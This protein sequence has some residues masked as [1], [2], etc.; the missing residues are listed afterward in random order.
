MD[1]GTAGWNTF[2]VQPVLCP[3]AVNTQFPLKNMISTIPLDREVREECE[4]YILGKYSLICSKI[5][6]SGGHSS[7]FR[8]VFEYSS[9]Q[10]WPFLSYKQSRRALS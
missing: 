1:A 9:T 2:A 7:K 10:S 5:A 4:L 6:I 3:R 8:G